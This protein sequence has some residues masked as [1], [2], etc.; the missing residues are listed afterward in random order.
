MGVIGFDRGVKKS[1]SFVDNFYGIIENWIYT[2]TI[3]L[4]FVVDKSII[5]HFFQISF[6][7]QNLYLI[8]HEFVAFP[9]LFFINFYHVHL[10][11]WHNNMRNYI[12]ELL[13]RVCSH[14]NS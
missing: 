6:K 7:F 14:T 8:H 11:T 10:F 12:G 1:T 3:D 4:K 13:L 2:T 5:L 9:L